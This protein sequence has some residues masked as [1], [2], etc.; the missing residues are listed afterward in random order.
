M[1]LRQV[2]LAARD[3]AAAV[4]DVR[5]VLGI[6]VAYRD[7]GVATFGLANAVFPVGDTFLEIVSPMQAGTSAGRFLDRHGDGGYMVILQT[8]DLQAHRRRMQGLGIRI[9][10]EIDLGQAAT[11]HLHP[12]DV[13]GAILSLDVM[14][15]PESWAWAGP[16]W[17]RAVRTEIVTEIAG[18]ELRAGAPEA[19]AERWGRIVERAPTRAAEGA[20]V[21]ALERGT[22]R[23]L[24]ETASP[25]DDRAPH[26]P[27]AL[28]TVVLRV[29]DRGAVLEKARA[30]GLATD[31]DT[32]RICGTAFRLLG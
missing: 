11:I 5:A 9:V 12:R 13:G 24:G 21:I 16:D 26:S 29:R 23:I 27:P 22:I 14:D 32:V 18:V 19:L 25:P 20:H 3:L 7:P 10:W 31:G 15:P 2:A 4:D 17:R 1:R 6:E 30:R 28:A 8:S